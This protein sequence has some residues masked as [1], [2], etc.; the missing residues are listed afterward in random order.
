M[1][2]LLKSAIFTAGIV[3]S[4]QAIHAQEK[5]ATWTNL[6]KEMKENP[7]IKTQLDQ[8]QETINTYIRE[9]KGK[10]KNGEKRI[11]P[12]VFHVI[13]E[14]GSEN[15]T[16]EQI[17]SQIDVINEDFNL[18]N[19]T[20]DSIPA[21]FKELAANCRI[22]FRLA[23][24][25]DMGNCTDGIV[26]VYSSKTSDATNQNDFK[27]L[28]YW[29]SNKYLNI[30]VVKSIDAGEGTMPGQILGYAQFPY[31]IVPIGLMSTDGITMRS[32]CIGRVG[33]A[34]IRGVAG[35]TLT[36][37][38]GHWLG[39][40]HIWGD[41][42]C[43]NDFVDDTPIA[44]GPNFGIC[45]KD[46]PYHATGPYSCHRPETDTVG[47]M[48]MNYMDY[49]DDK[50]YG[51]FTKGQLEIMDATLNSFRK[52]L[53][54][55]ANL[56]ATGT[57][58][59][60]VA[61]AIPCDPISDFSD[62]R[63][64]AGKLAYKN[65]MICEGA[66]V[67]FKDVSYGG[68]TPYSY[69]WEFE[70]GSPASGT[71]SQ[72]TVS[73]ANEGKYDVKH[74]VENANGSSTLVREDYVMVS[75][76]TADYSEGPYYEGFEQGGGFEKWISVNPDGSQNRW[77]HNPYLGA[78]GG[79]CFRLVN[80][81]N[82][83]NETDML[84]SPSYNM[85]SVPSPVLSFKLAYAERGG[86]PNDKLSIWTSTNCGQSW[87]LRK[88]WSGASLVTAGLYTTPY[89]PQSLN[90]WQTFYLPLSTV[91]SSA[92][93]RIMLE[94]TA[95]RP[96]SNNLYID[97]FSIGTSLGMSDLS[98]QTGFSIYPNPSAGQAKASLYLA[99]PAQVSLSVYDLTGRL[100]STPYQGIRQAGEMEVDI[101]LSNYS[102][103]LYT[104]RLE[105]NGQVAHQKLMI[106]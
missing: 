20:Y 47:E 8:W 4:G 89:A 25:D 83:Y 97:E 9:N 43:G 92:N 17:Q 45:W 60:D 37:E 93:L 27:S 55:A 64:L 67:T 54:S 71:S 80:Y 100:I 3:L 35:R 70:G 33:T 86:S 46:Y 29:N 12:V 50:C 6:Q 63:S 24:K 32:D 31:N 87:S 78:A 77:E 94:F 65:V 59:E 81:R 49:S 68:N 26:R 39:L 95:G 41:E 79:G 74:T 52:N 82:T 48:F 14:Y 19:D 21:P 22:E 42:Q 105:V 101:N 44:Y 106:E 10:P 73:Y 38:L 72:A 34:A 66:N 99:H 40:R 90:E 7:E 13:H 69:S 28:S 2:K 58:D 85:K 84:I 30:W 102:S 75:K 62:N 56:E 15:I 18:L 96:S 23:T 5:C 103:G 57:R 11:I 91:A 88:S 1:N 53:W 98:M 16:K 51:M 76:S 104:V 61:N 36:H